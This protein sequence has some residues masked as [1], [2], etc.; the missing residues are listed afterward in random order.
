MKVS[1]VY[2]SGSGNTEMISEF[3]EN[4][5]NEKKFEV[6]RQF[7]NEEA[8]IED[9]DVYCVGCPAYG[10]EDL[11]IYSLRPYYESLKPYLKEK[12]VV[13]FGSYDWGGGEWMEKWVEETLETEPKSVVALSA[14]LAPEESDFKT[15][16]LKL[17]DVTFS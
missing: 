3:L 17:D 2:F 15:Y 10:V 9:A 4:Y 12:P 1:I 14:E 8:L 7:V 5:F 11:E 13:L 16:Q 6:V